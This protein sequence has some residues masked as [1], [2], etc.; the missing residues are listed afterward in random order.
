MAIVWLKLSVEILLTVLY[1]DK[2]VEATTILP[3]LIKYENSQLV[4]LADL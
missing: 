4:V 3:V 1:V 2:R